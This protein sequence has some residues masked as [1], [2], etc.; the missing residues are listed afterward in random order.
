MRQ[1]IGQDAT[2]LHV[3]TATIKTHFTIL[4]IYDQSAV[5]GG[6]LRYRDILKYFDQR[7]TPLP[8]F[9]RKLVN[10]PFNLDAPYW[11]DDPSY[12]IES[13]V[14]HIGLPK[15]GDWRQFCILVGQI[16]AANMDLSKPLWDMHVVEGLDNITGLP[17]NSFAILTRL[18]HAIAD[19]TTA[20]GI[21]MAL[22]QPSGQKMP[23]APVGVREP[24]P[25]VSEMAVRAVVNNA[26]RFV[27]LEARL[28]RALPYIGE[29]LLP[30]A[31]KAL[32]LG[33][34]DADPAEAGFGAL[35]PAPA[36]IFNQ[37]MDYRR[38]FQ[39]RMFPLADIVAMRKAVEG[40]TVN[41]VVLTLIGEGLRRYL[42]RMKKSVKDDLQAICP[43]NI[44]SDKLTNASLAGND[45]SLMRANLRT[46]ESGLL[47]RMR[48]IAAG[49]KRSKEAQ[50]A[51]PVRELIAIGKEAPNLLLA[52][53]SRIAVQATLRSSSRRPLSNCIITNVPGPQEPLYFM[54]AKLVLFSGSPPSSPLTGPTFPVTSY[55]GKLFISFSG[56]ASWIGDPQGLAECL[57]EAY[58]A[59]CEEVLPLAILAGKTSAAAGKKPKTRKRPQPAARKPAKKRARRAPAK[60]AGAARSKAGARP[61]KKRSR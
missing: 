34:N 16:Q 41:D 49:T 38:V 51:A 8:V 55:D 26:T 42:A 1:L 40:A 33:S 58:E 56:A 50:R 36:T 29:A 32:S 47:E 39:L 23:K 14:R 30:M 44:R 19:G 48:R 21:M 9:R 15:P 18:H 52:L 17:P 37:E 24:L 12:H 5:P 57:T 20:R 10:V 46:T 22:H 35:T 53:G 4:T 6:A 13:H 60:A 43:I 45:I 59:M 3:E 54:G 7:L 2:F 27:K 31:G 28:L 25:T 11:V 61:R